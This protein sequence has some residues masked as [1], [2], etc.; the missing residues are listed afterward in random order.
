MT[1]TIRAPRPPAAPSLLSSPGG[2]TFLWLWSGQTISILGSGLTQFALGVWL[3]RET[4]QATPF[5]LTALFGF[6]PGIVL[7]PF[8]GVAADRWDRRTLMLLS[9][10]VQ[11]LATLALLGLLAAGRLELWAIY[12]LLALSS[13]ARAFQVPAH[14][15]SVSLL[16]PRESLGRA[17]G[18]SSM[19]QGVGDL[20]APIMAAAL[21]PVLGLPGV[22]LLDV[23]SFAVGAGITLALRIPRPPASE[24][25][26]KARGSL[27]VQAGAGWRY[28]R[29]RPG[30]LGLLT[31]FAGINFVM[32]MSG[33]LTAPLVLARTGGNAAALGAV[34]SSFGLG[35]IAGG[36][37][38]TTWGGPRPRVHGHFAPMIVAGLLAWP[39]VGL[40]GS[41]PVWMLGM[42][43]YGLCVPIVQGSSAAIWQSKVEPDLQGRVFATRR[44]VVQIAVP[45]AFLLAGPL[46]D[47]VFVPLAN[48]SLAPALGPLVGSGPE[49]GYA[50]MFLVTGVLAALNGLSGYLR[51]RTLHVERELP[52][53]K[54]PAPAA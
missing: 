34:S 6:L 22:M 25:G 1:V 27:W 38:M 18:L 11:G 51:P 36:L 43:V 8:A 10:L 40:G 12:G 39:A 29:E 26:R 4:G 17:N 32:P 23:L 19:S 24:A 14:M 41:L 42:F 30:L 16:V 49:A 9:D 46:A 33:V 53:Y 45:A 13:A 52:D 5:A 15:A 54:R 20:L 7:G 37:L 47:R 48:G 50:L 2:R 31:V 35:A 3:F 28:I 44:V 21:V